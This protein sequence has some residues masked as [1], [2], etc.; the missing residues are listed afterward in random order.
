MDPNN[1]DTAV[2]RDRLHLSYC[3]VSRF[4]PDALGARSSR[5][6]FRTNPSDRQRQQTVSLAGHDAPFFNAE[7]YG[8]SRETVEGNSDSL[9]DKP[10]PGFR[11]LRNV[12]QG[13]LGGRHS[14]A[15]TP[16]R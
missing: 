1:Q 15:A 14:L 3:L 8:T 2:M 12:A 16:K 11:W 6:I 5:Y 7:E 10:C 13:S 4:V 9:P